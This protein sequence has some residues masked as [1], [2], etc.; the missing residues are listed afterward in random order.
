MQAARAA[1]CCCA[2]AMPIVCLPAC[3]I[4]ASG[5]IPVGR[6]QVVRHRI[7][8]PANGGSNPPAPARFLRDISI[9]HEFEAVAEASFSLSQ[10]RHMKPSISAGFRGVTPARPPALQT[11]IEELVTW[12]D[13][14]R[15]LR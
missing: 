6:S 8:I 2:A 3:R 13:K 9:T 14:N 12:I 1:T 7:L 4:S 10:A 15:D 11:A 5:P